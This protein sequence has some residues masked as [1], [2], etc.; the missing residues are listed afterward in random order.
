MENNKLSY[1]ELEKNVQKLEHRIGLL[2]ERETVYRLIA[3][4]SSEWKVYTDMNAK[5]VLSSRYK[6]IFEDHNSI[7][8][9]IEPESGSIL[10]ANSSAVDFY[11]YDKDSLLS[12]C[13]QEID[14]L[15]TV[16]LKNERLKA[17]EQKQNYSIVPHKLANGDIRT[18]EV[19]SSPIDYG[20]KQVLFSIIHDITDR[21]KAEDLL[22]EHNLKFDIASDITKMAWWEMDIKTGNVTFNK[23]KAEMLGFPPEKFN[24]FTDFTNLVHP[25]DLDRIMDNMSKH[26]HGKADKYEVQYR[27]LTQS[28]EY[29]WFYDIG[30][31]FKRDVN[32]RPLNLFGAVLDITQRKVTEIALREAKEK[33]E[34]SEKKYRLIAENT[35]D[36]IMII[37]ADTQ[38]KYVSP[39]HIKQNGYSEEE[40]L[41][42][43]AETIF[44][45]IHPEDRE[46]LFATIFNAIVEK[47]T[48]LVYSYRVKHKGGH[49]FWREDNARFN[50]DIFG[51][52]IDTYVIS[53][54]IT[55]R[56]R[57][58]LELQNYREH[59]EELVKTRTL[60][61]EKVNATKDKFLSIIAHD[62][63]NPFSG[64]ITTAELLMLSLEEIKDQKILKRIKRIFD[65]GQSAHKLLENLLVWA[66]SQT[67][68]IEFKSE[69]IDAGA[70][71]IDIF[72]LHENACLTK[73]IQLENEIGPDIQLVG[74]RNMLNTILRNLVGNAI[75]Y[76]PKSGNI[77][78]TAS[79][80]VSFIEFSIAD[81]GVGISEEQID[82]IFRISEKTSTPGTENEMGTGLGLILCKEFVEKHGGRIWAESEPGKGSVFKFTIPLNN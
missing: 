67:G 32:G 35:S 45:M 76:T 16:Q 14:T 18:V 75:K 34:L 70:L 60:E 62:L 73:N 1:A 52:H 53:R 81:S 13:I 79:K 46:N 28:G 31:I 15:P 8:M 69:N 6:N 77:K 63:K 37:G 47:K 22:N 55:E 33:A 17:M 68:R 2:Q 7:M 57:N 65:A 27:I 56:K 64:I 29:K 49:Y 74:D 36:G 54:D 39:T 23:L 30:S 72:K 3:D 80:Q 5:L 21:K 10:E 59:L 44:N 78:I 48:E 51:N 38:V 50:Y 43:N 41:S 26:I 61:L 71:V 12:M 58:E 11:G 42:R 25:D 66:S 4:E 20:D 24:H 82:K 9:I 40:E 19:H